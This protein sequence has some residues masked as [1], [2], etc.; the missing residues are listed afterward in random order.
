MGRKKHLV[1]LTVKEP[2]ISTKRYSDNAFAKVLARTLSKKPNCT[3]PSVRIEEIRQAKIYGVRP[4]RTFRQAAT[5]YLE[6]NQHKASL[7]VEAM[8]IK[9]LDKFI[10]QLS[11]ESVHM[12]NLQA[13]IKKREK[14]KVKK[15]TINYGLQVVRQ[16][17][18]LAMDT[19]KDEDNLSWLHIRHLKLSCCLKRTGMILIP[20]LKMN[21][22]GYSLSFPFICEE[23]LCLQSTQDVVIRRFVI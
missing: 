23:W 13:Y 11:L 9:I 10:G 18:N 2:G 5:K 7:H 20:Y 22:Q 8:H 19:W 15:R 12:C 16:I 17:L 3:S 21:K 6:E 14:D 1:S 4:K